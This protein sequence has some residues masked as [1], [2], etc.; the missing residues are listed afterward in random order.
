[1]LFCHVIPARAGI[2]K[3]LRKL[4]FL[5]RGN[6]LKVLLHWLIKLKPDGIAG[7]PC[8]KGESRIS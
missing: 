7:R 4:D 2:L 8:P 3:V 1:V 6:D 5:L